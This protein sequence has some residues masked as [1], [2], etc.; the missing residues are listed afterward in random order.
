VQRRKSRLK[1]VLGLAAC[2]AAILV[3]SGFEGPPAAVAEPLVAGDHITRIVRGRTVC[4]DTNNNNAYCGTEHWT[5]FTHGNGARYLHVVADSPRD[6]SV[7]HAVVRVAPNA[8]VAEA[9]AS[10]SRDSRFLGSTLVAPQEDANMVAVNDTNFEGDKATVRVERVELLGAQT[11]IGTGPASADGLHFIDYD[12][13]AGGEQERP[14]YW[15]GG[16]YGTMRGATVISRNILLGKEPLTL[17][18]GSTHEATHFRMISGTEVWL[19][20]PDFALLRM[21]LKFGAANGLRF[22]TVE[23]HISEQP[24]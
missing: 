1:R 20:E 10:V 15:V 3:V 2:S 16:R 8:G 22:D 11:S 5:L 9:F 17:A 24:E 23:L 7:K 13:E 6:D 21:E 19:L 4:S 14:V 12:Q 18:D